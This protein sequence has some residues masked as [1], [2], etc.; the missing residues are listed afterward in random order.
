[1]YIQY[2]YTIYMYTYI[3]HIFFKEAIVIH[4]DLT[5]IISDLLDSGSFSTTGNTLIFCI[6]RMKDCNCVTDAVCL[7]VKARSQYDRNFTLH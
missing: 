5:L 1:M 7:L 4:V 3:V 6:L 2:S